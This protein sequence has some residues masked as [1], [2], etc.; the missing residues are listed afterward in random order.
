MP[1][2]VLRTESLCKKYQTHFWSK[3]KV[4][5]HDLNLEVNSGEVFGFLGPNGAGKTTSIKAILNIVR[6]TTGRA[7]IFGEDVGRHP[8]VLAKVGFLPENPYF[9]DHLKGREFLDTCARLFGMSK[10]ERRRRISELLDLV[11]LEDSGDVQLRKYSKGMLQRIGL[12]QALVNNP[13]LVI[14]DEPLTGLDPLGRKQV[15]DL[16]L[17]LKEQGKTIFFSSHILPDVEMLC[18]RVGI[19]WQGRLVKTGRLDQLLSEKVESVELTVDNLDPKFRP[20]VSALA[21]KTVERDDKLML[22]FSD[23]PAADKALKLCLERGGRVV[24]F[25]PQRRSLEQVFL[26]EVKP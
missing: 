1:Q 13:D 10:P 22:T 12:A 2:V 20:E 7:Y 14:L 3:I 15:K 24:S 9:Y 5:L 17:S 23:Q 26:E 4:A 16:I 6:P 21:A 8:G 19:I 11:G 18:D 25:I